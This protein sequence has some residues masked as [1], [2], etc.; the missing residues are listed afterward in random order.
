MKSEHEI[1][2]EI[3]L[4]L[5][6]N[7]CTVFRGQV[8]RILLSDGRWFDTGLPKGFADLFG[9]RHADGK[10]FFIEVK[11]EGGRVRPEQEK[12]IEAMRQK[13]ALCGICR[14]AA[15]ALE[16]VAWKTDM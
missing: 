11:R 3:R 14:S 2:N 5:S 8:G 15:Q 4:M 12:F 7:G 9:F 1:Q 10:M 13:G 16:V 6:R